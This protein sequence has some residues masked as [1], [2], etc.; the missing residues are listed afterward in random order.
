VAASSGVSIGFKS[1]S[2]VKLRKRALETGSCPHQ[3]CRRGKGSN[4]QKPGRFLSIK[5]EGSGERK[6]GPKLRKIEE[7]KGGTKEGK[8]RMVL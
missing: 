4:S 1:W 6:K 7:S 3:G 8:K 2:E 5:K